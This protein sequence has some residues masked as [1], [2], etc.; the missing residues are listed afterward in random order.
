MNQTYIQPTLNLQGEKKLNEPWG[1]DIQSKEEN[2]VRIFFQNINSIQINQPDKWENIIKTLMIQYKSDIIGSCETGLYWKQPETRQKIHN[3]TRKHLKIKTNINH[4]KNKATS[5][6][7]FLP[8]GTMT[9]TTGFWTGRIMSPLTDPAEMGRWSGTKYNLKN[10]RHLYII[11]AYRTCPIPSNIVLTKSN[12]SY[13]QQ[14]FMLKENGIQ[15]PNLRKQFVDDM[16]QFIQNLQL[17]AKDM[18]LLMMDANEE[19]GKETI[20]IINLIT[21]GGLQD[22]FTTHHG[23]SCEIETFIKGTKRIDYILGT[24]NIIPYIKQCGY[25]PFQS[26]TISDHRGLFL[27]L[28]ESL[29]D[30]KNIIIEQPKREIGLHCNMETTKKYKDYI[31]KQFENHNIKKRSETLYDKSNTINLFEDKKLLLK[32]LNAID[33][34]VTK[35]LLKAEKRNGRDPINSILKNVRTHHLKAAVRYCQITISSLKTHK[36]FKH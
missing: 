36:D 32:E 26:G 10:D 24:P 34:Q 12:S 8:G 7:S 22:L 9:I 13:T 28:C 31:T 3:N 4:S 20:G 14:Y 19:I 16:L 30:N 6:T 35:I 11:S 18:L 23:R 27:D 1:D 2:T 29:I 33:L 15:D 21:K 25:L 5:G 17:R